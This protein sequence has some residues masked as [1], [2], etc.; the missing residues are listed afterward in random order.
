MQRTG[1]EK[2]PGLLKTEEK[3]KADP[4]IRRTVISIKVVNNTL[5]FSFSNLRKSRFLGLIFICLIPHLDIKCKIDRQRIA[6]DRI[7]LGNKSHINNIGRCRLASK[8]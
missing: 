1:K 7:F 8:F 2:K 5:P 3:I 4:K 6:F